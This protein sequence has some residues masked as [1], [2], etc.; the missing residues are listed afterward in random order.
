SLDRLVA[1]KVLSNAQLTNSRVLPRFMREVQ[2]AARLDH[3][4]IITAHDAGVSEGRY[5]LVMEY[6]DGR[7]LNAWIKHYGRLPIAW[8]CEFI[9]QSALGLQHAHE[10]GLVH[11]DIKPANLVVIWKDPEAEPVVKILDL[12]LARSIR[13]TERE[14]AGPGAE[15]LD[16]DTV[17]QDGQIVGTPDY[18]SPEQIRGEHVDI[19]SDVFSLGCTLY[20]LLTGQIPFGGATVF[21]KL[22]NRVAENAPPAVSARSLCADVPPELDAVITKMLDRQAEKRFRR[23]SEVAQA[24][25]PFALRKKSKPIASR[26]ASSASHLSAAHDPTPPVSESLAA[27]VHAV[28]RAET[29]EPPRAAPA[30]AVALSATT[31]GATAARGA[32]APTAQ[33]VGA[34]TRAAGGLPAGGALLEIGPRGEPSSARGHST[35]GAQPNRDGAPDVVQS[36][37][38]QPLPLAPARPQGDSQPR[39]VPVL[40]LSETQESV[41]ARQ[42]RE[43]LRRRSEWTTRVFASLIAAALLGLLWRLLG[44]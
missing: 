4:N 2:A 23:P 1:I 18:L 36:L 17:T 33:S 21:D 20:K 35:S 43:A 28:P 16:G 39:G 12:G 24:L 26:G 14:L 11:R 34:A 44:G 32:I 6:A 5:F 10:Q 7:D 27:T 19:R 30:V 40:R 9:R 3:G 22:Q 25:E 15:W 31:P 13:E 37:L 38:P 8:A 42:R 29:Y 41:A